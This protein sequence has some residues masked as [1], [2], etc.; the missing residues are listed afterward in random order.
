MVNEYESLLAAN[1]S[2]VGD[3]LTDRLHDFAG[4]K[5]ALV[6]AQDDLAGLP[7]GAQDDSFASSK[8]CKNEGDEDDFL[9]DEH[10]YQHGKVETRVQHLTTAAAT[11]QRGEDEREPHLVQNDVSRSLFCDF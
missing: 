5:D 2:Y 11:S 3:L 6:G 7:S 4:C 10:Q 9:Q 1:P 8:R